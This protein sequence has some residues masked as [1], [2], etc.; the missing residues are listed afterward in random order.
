MLDKV[1]PKFI[2]V[3]FERSLAWEDSVVPDDS[4]STS[5]ISCLRQAC[6]SLH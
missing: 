2:I 1:Y 6:A 5:L 4:W 3:F